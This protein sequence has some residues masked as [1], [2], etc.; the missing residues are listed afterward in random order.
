MVVWYLLFVKK[1]KRKRRTDW[2]LYEKKKE[3]VLIQSKKNWWLLGRD[4]GVV[5]VRSRLCVCE[6][7]LVLLEV[8]VN[9][10]WNC[11][12]FGVYIIDSWVKQYC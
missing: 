12:T 2:R 6:W 7:F 11:R 9:G 1:E 10:G 5:V 3:L 4:C 8:S